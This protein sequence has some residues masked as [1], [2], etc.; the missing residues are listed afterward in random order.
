MS[1][2][3]NLD[4]RA[5]L[6]Q[7]AVL[8]GATALPLEALAAPRRRA[9]RFLAAPQYAL[10]SAVADTLLPVT[11]TPGALA[12]QVPARIDSLL[13]NWASAETRSAIAGAL[14]RID[15]AARAQKMAGFASLSA[16]NRATVLRPHDLASLKKVPPPPGAPKANFFAS[17]NYVADPGYLKLKG[18]VLQLYY[19]SPVGVA[20]EL[21]YDHVPGK[22]QPSI[23]ITPASRPELGT[24]PF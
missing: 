14:G 21:L 11:D 19:F 1:E 18:L 3:L 24:G 4:R 6:A 15:A 10:L 17:A 13:R 8:I 7:L 5:A 2:F 16:A 22:F 9:R 23:K 12:A 20:N